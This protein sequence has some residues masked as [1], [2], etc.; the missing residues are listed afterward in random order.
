MFL[1][2][3][4][5]RKHLNDILIL[6]SELLGPYLP[7]LRLDHVKIKKKCMRYRESTNEI[8]RAPIQQKLYLKSALDPVVGKQY[9]FHETCN[10]Q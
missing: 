4:E 1:I 8:S 6:N 10:N 3:P 5:R 9:F 2:G 7:R